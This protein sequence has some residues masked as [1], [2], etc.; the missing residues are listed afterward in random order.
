MSIVPPWIADSTCTSPP[1]TAPGNSLT[2]IL[3]PLFC[4]DQVGELLAADRDRVPCR[5]GG[6]PTERL[7][8]HLR[9]RVPPTVTSAPHATAS[10]NFV[11]CFI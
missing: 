4:R 2:C 1:S 3:P 8:P 5:I 7:L 10:I 9:L 11:D 6:R